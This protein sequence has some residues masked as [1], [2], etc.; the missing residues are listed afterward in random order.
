ME[1]VNQHDPTDD[2]T[3]LVPATPRTSVI[4][5]NN[6][7]AV[8]GNTDLGLPS[9]SGLDNKCTCM[10]CLY[11]GTSKGADRIERHDV[12]H[13]GTTMTAHIC[14]LPDCDVRYLS[15][16]VLYNM[17]DLARHERAHFGKPGNYRCLE[18]GCK[19]TAKKFAD[20]KRHTLGSHRTNPTK[21]P[22]P[23]SVCKFSGD[24][25][26]TR[27]DKLK[28]HYRNVHHGK[29]VPGKANQPIKPN[30]NG[31]KSIKAKPAGGK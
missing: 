25:G 17:L 13:Y 26:F 23:S 28:S 5:P 24:N 14:R 9:I 6:T 1:Y 30:M 16:Y 7:H 10:I 11:L 4:E 19:T 12:V 8:G 29:A 2:G 31:A 15:A 22:C 3:L 20:L 27:E 21:F 18:K